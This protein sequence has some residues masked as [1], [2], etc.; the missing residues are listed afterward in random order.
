MKRIGAKKKVLSPAGSPGIGKERAHSLIVYYDQRAESI[1]RNEKKPK[2]RRQLKTKRLLQTCRRLRRRR[3]LFRE[4]ELR[5][6]RGLDVLLCALECYRFFL[7]GREKRH[8]AGARVQQQ[9]QVCKSQIRM[10]IRKFWSCLG[11]KVFANAK[12]NGIS[13]GNSLWQLE[14]KD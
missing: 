4:P 12:S 7:S 14:H 10:G 5:T 13:M 8:R 2:E 6:Y 9:V 3:N 11:K 1:K